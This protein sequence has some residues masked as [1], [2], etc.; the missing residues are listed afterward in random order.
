M[1]IVIDD[2]KL[3]ELLFAAYVKTLADIRSAGKKID[4]KELRQ[5]LHEFAAF[6]SVETREERNASI[7]KVM[8]LL[9]GDKNAKSN[10][11]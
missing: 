11:G 5:A 7:D 9:K 3:E 8:N 2:K 6:Y 4:E 1:K 10:I